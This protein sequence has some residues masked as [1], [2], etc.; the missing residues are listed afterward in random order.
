MNFF[1]ALLGD[2][3][4]FSALAW[5]AGYGALGPAT[6]L[7]LGGRAKL[8][9]FAEVFVLTISALYLFITL[10]QIFGLGTQ[11]PRSSEPQVQRLLAIG[12]VLTVGFLY[13]RRRARALHEPLPPSAPAPTDE[14]PRS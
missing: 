4:L 12:A 7:R 10:D 9:L 6:G 5:F 2:A 11:A 1:Y 8:R 13:T 14:S 3:L